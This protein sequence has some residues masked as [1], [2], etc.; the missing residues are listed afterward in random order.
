MDNRGGGGGGTIATRQFAK[1][2]A[3]RLHASCSPTRRRWR[4]APSLFPNVGYDPR[5]DFAPIG[6]IASA[7]ACWWRIPRLPAQS[8]AELIALCARPAPAVP[9]RLARRRHGQ[10][11]GGRALC[12][13][14]RR[15]AHAHS[16]Q[17]LGP[18]INDLIGGHVLVAVHAHPGGRGPIAAGSSARSASPDQTLALLPDVP[19]IAESGLPGFEV[20]ATLRPRGAGRHAA[21]DRRPLN[22][23]AHA[24]LATDEVKQADRQRGRR[25]V[26]GTPGGAMPPTS[27][28]RD[29]VVGAD[30]DRSAGSRKSMKV[31]TMS[32]RLTTSLAVAASRR[33]SRSRRPRVAQDYPTRPITLVVPYAAGGGNDVMARIVAD[34]MSAT[35]GQQIVIENRGGAGGSIATRAGRACRARRLHARPRRHRHAGDQSDALSQCRLRPA[36]GFRAGRADRHQRAGRAG[37]PVG[38]GEDASAS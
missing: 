12:P 25:A 19:T 3:R 14:G 6:L 15:Q 20:G 37:Q 38:A 21:A 11:S 7:S 18:A 28:R 5:K 8:V 23:R 30:Q 1:S 31:R 26:A 4:S 34:K 35:L 24:A 17:G 36:Q 29:Q 13:D 2:R 33:C 27:T 32:A 9:I 22:K 16:L 10:P